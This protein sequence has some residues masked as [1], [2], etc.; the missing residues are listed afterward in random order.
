[1]KYGFITGLPRSGS[2]WLANYLSYGSCM[3]IHD[4]W[5][6][7]TPDEI[8]SKIDRSSVLAGGTSDPANVMYVDEIDRVFP[9][10]K[11]VVVTR[12]PKDVEESCNA[13]NFP[14]H[15]W[16]DNLKKLMSTRD[17][18]KV[19]FSK[20]FTDADKIGKFIYDDWSCPGWRKS[21]LKD[22]NVQVHFGRVSEQ[23]KVPEVLNEVP[24]LT[25]SKME[26]LRLLKD[27]VKNDQHAMRFVTQAMRVSELYK[28][29]DQ[30]KPVDIKGA[31]SVLEEIST[32]WMI[33][34]FVRNFSG[35]LSSAIASAIEKYSNT[36]DRSHCW[37]DLDLL[38]SVVYHF[39][40]LDGSKEYMPKIRA[41]SDKIQK[42]NEWA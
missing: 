22:M 42:G 20:I 6:L 8:K 25:P 3:M 40:G 4:A 18:L 17:V 36:S 13:I 14:F 15:D 23:F 39:Q 12:N 11:W 10:A 19:P 35:T 5:K 9:E 38:S 16:T 1:M 37:L 28:Q 26:F 33:S 2:A 41:L 34:P 31:K 27:I 21:Q 7:G 32:E 29:L 24:A 30:G